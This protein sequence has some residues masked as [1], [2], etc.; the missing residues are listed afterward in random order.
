MVRKME[1]CFLFE[2]S[3][4]I[5]DVYNGLLFGVKA[6]HIGFSVVTSF[7]L[8]VNSFSYGTVIFAFWKKESGFNGIL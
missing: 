6:I 5:I 7:N 3:L 2:P 8:T 1:F 4:C